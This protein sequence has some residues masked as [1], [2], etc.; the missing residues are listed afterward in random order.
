MKKLTTLIITFFLLTTGLNSMANNHIIDYLRKVLVELEKIESAT[1]TQQ[2]EG[3]QHGDAV[4]YQILNYFVKEFN[5]PADTTIGASWANFSYEMPAKLAYAYNGKVRAVVYHENKGIIIDDFARFANLPYIPIMP[6]FFNYTKSIIH[7][8]ISTTDNT[9]LDLTDHD[10]YYHF[11][12]VINEDRQ[13]EFFGRAYRMPPVSHILDKTSI[14]ELWICKSNNLPYKYRREMF[15]DI[16]V[17]FVS[18]V[19]LNTLSIDDFNIHDFFPAD[20]EI[21]TVQEHQDR[22]NQPSPNRLIGRK[23]PDWTLNDKDEQ[24]MSLSDLKGRVSLINFTGIGCGPCHAA[25][26]FLKELR[27]TFGKDEFELV[28]MEFWIRSSQSLQNYSRR[29]ELNYHLLSGTDRVIRDY[30]TGGAVPFFF[31]LDRD[32]TVRKVIR[33][34]SKETTGQEILEAISELI[35]AG[36][37][38]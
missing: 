3:W 2:R 6:P 9:I 36:T 37:S 29:N 17:R 10:N 34:Y 1:Y 32:L 12:L 20:Y 15:Q 33:G 35:L 5:N 4:P 16:V 13:I 18:N 23:A 28:A 11:R 27:E 38:K 24:P 26:P 19:E 30:Q 21:R 8:A 22:R 14:Y 7:Y 31:I 25:I